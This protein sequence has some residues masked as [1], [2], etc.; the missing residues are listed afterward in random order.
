MIKYP[1][2]VY[3]TVSEGRILWIA[4]SKR[5]NGCI[6][7]NSGGFIAYGSGI[8]HQKLHPIGYNVIIE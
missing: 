1:F 2:E 8:N 5:F 4:K 3:K 6:G 7:S